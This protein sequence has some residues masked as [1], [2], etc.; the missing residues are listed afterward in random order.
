[1]SFFR[2]LLWWL[3]LAAF[4]ALAFELL[5]PD[6]GEVLIRWHGLT[7]TT[8]VAFLLVGWALLWFACWAAWTVLSLPFTAWQRLAQSQAR[9]R[10]VNGLAALHEGR[11]ARAGSL[12]EKAA[13]EAGVSSV[14]RNAARQAALRRGDIEEAA[15]Q[16]SE[17]ARIDPLSAALNVAETALDQG[18]PHLALDA[19]APWA[20]HRAQPPRALLMR[21]QALVELGRAI[22]ALPLLGAMR[23]DSAVP[24]ARLDSLER[25]WQGAALRQSAHANELHQRWTDTPGRL[26]AEPDVLADFA[27]RAGELGL[28][29]EAAERL[30]ASIE[31]QWNENLVLQLARLPASRED[32]RLARAQSWLDAHPSSPALLLALGRLSRRAQHLGQAEDLLHRAV[33]QGGGAAAWEELG[34]LYTARQDAERAQVSYANALRSLRGEPVRPLTGRSLREQIADEAVTEMRNEHGLPQLRS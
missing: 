22:D 14:A 34:K 29:T 16:Q 9:N 4:G 30:I 2:T 20:D 33:A 21:G 23:Q 12:L 1:M 19:L 24:P 27:Q 3:L 8:T 10:L 5:A 13:E 26:Q 31:Q 18:R 15:V 28:E 25:D 7:I 32:S 17:L 11:H 6:L